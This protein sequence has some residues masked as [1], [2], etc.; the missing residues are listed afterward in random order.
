[1][2]VDVSVQRRRVS[3][4]RVSLDGFGPSHT[5]RAIDYLLAEQTPEDAWYGRWGVN[6]VYGT[7][8]VLRALTSVDPS[9]HPR[10]GRL[11]EAVR[12]GVDWLRSVQNPDGGFGE[13]SA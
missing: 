5:R 2:I 7:S 11:R 12:R 13:S 8:G 3:T 9:R 6:Y 1:M 4:A 10:P